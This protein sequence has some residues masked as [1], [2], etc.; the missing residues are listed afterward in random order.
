MRSLQE[1]EARTALLRSRAA[2]KQI[3]DVKSPD[4]TALVLDA[5]DK[6]KHINF[7]ADI[8]EGVRSNTAH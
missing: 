1:Q 5:D 7:F 6:P 3:K 2:K 4:T 8:E